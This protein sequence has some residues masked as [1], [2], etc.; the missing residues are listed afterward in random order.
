[1]REEDFDVESY[2]LSLTPKRFNFLTNTNSASKR[3]LT[4]PDRSMTLTIR[5]SVL[6]SI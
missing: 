2:E 1:M 3:A 4:M 6:L 5:D